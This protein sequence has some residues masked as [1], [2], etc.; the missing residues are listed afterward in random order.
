MTETAFE[1]YKHALRRGHVAALRGRLDEALAAY[2]E[3]GT[4]AP[5]RT[6]PLTSRASVLARLSRH[7]DAL[8]AFDQALARTRSRPR[9]SGELAVT[10]D[11][12]LSRLNAFHLHARLRPLL[13]EIAAHRLLKRYGVDLDA[14][15]GRAR[16][17]VGASAWSVVRPNRPPPA[18]RLAPGPTLAEL[19]E[20]LTELER[21]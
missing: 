2:D 3:A 18:D 19:R 6:L 8:A 14:E 17:L 5:D 7:H 9:D 13:R 11:I 20:V 4:L 12:E 10:R 16:E 21:V 1:R 15:P